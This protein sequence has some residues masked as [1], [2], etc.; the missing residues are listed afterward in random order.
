MLIAYGSKIVY[1]S[2]SVDGAV[3][4]NVLQ[5]E[6]KMIKF[7]NTAQYRVA[8]ELGSVL[9]AYN[10]LING[11]IKFKQRLSGSQIERNYIVINNLFPVCSITAGNKHS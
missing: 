11:P 5:D 9:N 1:L 10:I 6:I 7:D 3:D 4:F 8:K 2:I